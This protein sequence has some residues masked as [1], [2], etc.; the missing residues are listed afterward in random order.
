[1]PERLIKTVGNLSKFYA[2]NQQEFVEGILQ[3]G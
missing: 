1:M 2:Y 3:L